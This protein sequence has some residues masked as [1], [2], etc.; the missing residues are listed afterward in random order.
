MPKRQ[1]TS[2]IILILFSGLINAATIK[3]G[4]ILLNKGHLKESAKIFLEI[5]NSKSSADKKAKAYFYMVKTKSSIKKRKSGYI[6]FI[7][8]FKNHSFKSKAYYNL[9]NLC[10]LENSLDEAK[11]YLSKIK[12]A[13]LRPELRNK[14]LLNLAEI[15]LKKK[16]PVQAIAYLDKIL[17]NKTWNPFYIKALLRKAEAFI[18]MKNYKKAE[19]TYLSL[20]EK[21]PLNSA[22]AAAYYRLGNLAILQKDNKLA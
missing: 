1:F 15:E 10:L 3:Q 14:V 21:F 22:S 16:R 8:L 17:I 13:D 6:R 18:I 9:A 2:L 20:L 5:Y 7:K 11:K 19:K 12:T 4:L